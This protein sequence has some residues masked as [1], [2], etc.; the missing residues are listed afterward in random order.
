MKFL[1]RSIPKPPR[2]TPHHQHR[3]LID[4]AAVKCV[5]DRALDHAVEKERNLKSLL[6]LKTLI[7]T[8]P[9]KSLP[10]S[11][12]SQHRD[13]LRIPIRPID[14]IRQYPSVFHEFLPGNVGITPHVKLTPEVL[15][16]DA[17][18]SLI[19]HSESHRQDAANR[20][21]K[22]LM[23][24]KINRIPLR[25]IDCLKWDLGLPQDY[26]KS[27]VPEF[28]DYF[29]VTSGND[30]SLELVCWSN[31][32]A[33]SV[34]EKKERGYEKGMPIAFPLQYS[35]GFEI[36]KKFKKSVDEWQKLPYIS[37]YENALHLSAN[38]DKSDR[39][40]VAV[41]H[42]LLHLFVPK[43]TERDNIL[44]LGEYLGIRSRLKRALLNH[45]GIFYVSSKVRTHTVVL[46]EAYKRDLLIGNDRNHPLMGMRSKYIHLM[47]MVKK[48]TKG[49][50][51][52]G[53]RSP[54]QKINKKDKRK[55]PRE[56]STLKSDHLQH[57]DLGLTT[58]E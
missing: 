10:L 45:P 7:G 9:T 39:W 3:T 44:C 13:S 17:E 14:F 18:E 25:I 42:E 2:R 56:S 41:L 51:V 31:E 12:I 43:K 6:S 37:P 21:L 22:L 35:R 36:D 49:K 32:L 33:K 48:D 28:P 26:T 50:N 20:L 54:N 1:L 16:L 53:G 19:Y 57:P 23:I 24:G 5:R 4:A 30:E 46:R 8:E 38:S 11:V 15:D 47:N 52:Q 34:I 55:M 40:A 27:I 58:K 29:K